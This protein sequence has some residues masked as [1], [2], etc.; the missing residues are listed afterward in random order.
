M[1]EKTLEELW[2]DFSNDL[3]K[4]KQECS[5]KWGYNN[6]YSR[7]FVN[8]AISMEHIFDESHL[9]KLFLSLLELDTGYSTMTLIKCFIALKKKLHDRLFMDQFKD[10]LIKKIEEYQHLNCLFINQVTK[11]KFRGLMTIL[12][13]CREQIYK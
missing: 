10:K 4:I 12:T 3:G 5:K 7:N 9:I 1:A 2:P 6:L 11:M 13:E 8:K